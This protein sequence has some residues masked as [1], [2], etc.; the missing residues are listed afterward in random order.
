MT[1]RVCGGKNEALHFECFKETPAS[2]TMLLELQIYLSMGFS[3]GKKYI[4]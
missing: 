3:N 2:A 4:S 1:I